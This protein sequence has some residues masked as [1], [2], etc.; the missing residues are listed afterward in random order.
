MRTVVLCI[1]L[2]ILLLV[3]VVVYRVTGREDVRAKTPETTD[4]ICVN[5]ACK[6]SETILTEESAQYFTQL[7]FHMLDDG[8]VV[9]KC[10]ECKNLSWRLKDE[11]V[12]PEAPAPTA[13]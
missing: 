12:P 10:P 8:Q 1:V 9:L 7:E 5:P 3:A 2:A 6:H 4:Y 13:P 11:I